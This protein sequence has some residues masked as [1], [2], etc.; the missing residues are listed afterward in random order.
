MAFCAL[1]QKIFVPSCIIF[2]AFLNLRPLALCL[3]LLFPGDNFSMTVHLNLW[4]LV[5]S[6]ARKKRNFP[7]LMVIDN[8]KQDETQKLKCLLAWQIIFLWLVLIWR[9]EQEERKFVEGG[10]CWTH[11]W[12]VLSFFAPW[13]D[14]KFPRDINFE[15]ILNKARAIVLNIMFHLAELS[16][17]KSSCNKFCVYNVE[18][19]M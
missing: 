8:Y 7:F 6:G 1:L 3:E 14:M 16:S 13:Q 11:E 9:S 4:R 15:F 2:V 5:K 10:F 19:I 12:R 17:E 18:Q